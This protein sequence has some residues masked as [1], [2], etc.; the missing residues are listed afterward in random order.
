[1]P[2]GFHHDAVASSATAVKAPPIPWARTPIA[3][4][5]LRRKRRGQKHQGHHGQKGFEHTPLP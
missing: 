2:A 4:V 5:V 1:M 3:S